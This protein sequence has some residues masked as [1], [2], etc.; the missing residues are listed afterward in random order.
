[1][2]TLHRTLAGV[3]SIDHFALNVPSLQET[4]RF[5]T[6]FG[7][8]VEY[9]DD[10]LRIRTFDAE[11]VWARLFAARAE[12]LAYLSLGCHEQDFDALQA[13]V[14]AAGGSPAEP[15]AR[16]NSAGFW[17]RDPDGNLL[18]IRGAA[19]TQPD[20]KALLADCNVPPGTRGVLGRSQATSVRPTRLSHLLLFTPDVSRTI[21]FYE[22]AVGLGL[23]DRSADIIAFMHARHGCDHHLL[24]F[25]NSAGKGF[26]HSAWDV[27]G[28]NDIGLGSMQMKNAGYGKQW[29]VARHV[30]GSNYFVYTQ[31][32]WGS[33]WE[34]S[35]H[36][37]YIPAGMDWHAGDFPAEDSLYLWGPDVPADFVDNNEV[38]P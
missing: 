24:A 8:R 10:E 3:H 17:F 22:T 34:Y 33:W 31:D 32:P 19:K 27:P 14:M 12:N 7:L 30:L 36:I 38:P 20:A 2:T 18:Q 29:G 25:A 26:H 4:E 15:H 11:H 9:G 37:D 16:A 28:F 23:T 35:S 5:L 1:M 6:A 13:Q 21:A